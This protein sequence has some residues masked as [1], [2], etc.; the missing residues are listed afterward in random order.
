MNLLHQEKLDVGKSGGELL[1]LQEP[2]VPK[3]RENRDMKDDQFSR[4]EQ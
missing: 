3:H 4:S 1:S 2:G